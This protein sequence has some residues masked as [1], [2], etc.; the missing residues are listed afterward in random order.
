MP[1]F[2][3]IAGE[4]SGDLLGAR[5][6]QALKKKAPGSVFRGI[7]GPRMRD[8]G[9]EL[10]FPQEELAHFGLFELLKHVPHLLRRM[11]ETVAEVRRVKPDALITIDAPDFCFRVAKRLKGEVPLI[12]YVAP[13]VWA[14]RPGRAKKIAQ[15]LDHLMV[16]LPFEPVYFEREGLA[17]TFVGH[18]IV[19]SGAGQGDGE[20]FR[21]R[22]AL[23]REAKLVAVLPGSRMSEIAKLLPIFRETLHLLQGRHSSLRVVIPAAPG[24]ASYLKEHTK[25]WP[26]PVLV[27]EGDAEKY[28]AFAACRAALACSGTVA[29]ELA[30]ARL[31]A[32]IAYKISKLTYKLY[33]R[34]IKVR[35]ANLVNLMH[36]KMLVPEFI[37]QDCT[38]EKLAASLDEIM[39]DEAAR[40]KQIE[41]LSDVASWLGQGQFV[42][43]ER[44]A[45]TV[46]RVSNN[47]ITLPLRACCEGS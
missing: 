3:L 33:R 28:G 20:A 13:T 30:M 12:H 29:V 36:D 11:K 42:P 34:L 5:L 26:L 47:M 1:D 4:A 18:P 40:K 15:F 19:E 46:L 44:A 39:T 9:L 45:E 25:D 14:W 10:F 24:L 41:G 43:S 21:A 17:S 27:V 31:P 8:E 35:Y 37:Q 6:M 23:P 2:F 38:P 16:L 7:G 32:V 22:H